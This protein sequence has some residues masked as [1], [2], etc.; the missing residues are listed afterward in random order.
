MM[1]TERMVI[2][3]KI[4]TTALAMIMITVMGLSSSA[5]ASEKVETDSYEAILDSINKE[6][7]LNLGY[8]P[9]DASVNIE[10]YENIA[11]KLAIQQRE[12]LN[13]IALR[14]AGSLSAPAYPSTAALASSVVKTKT[15]PVWNFEGDFN[16]Q[17]TYTVFDNNTISLCRNATTKSTPSA[18]IANTYLTNISAPTYRVID[19]GMTSTVKFTATIHYNSIVGFENM[20]LYTEFYY[21]D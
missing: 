1:G 5:F 16:I 19:S 17:A 14:E 21:N 13:Y 9:V 8:V 10:E 2:M 3:K 12:L 11:R 20:S 18:I 15:K 6:Y 4:I 7:N